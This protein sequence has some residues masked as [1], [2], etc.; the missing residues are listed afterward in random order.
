[1]LLMIENL[2]ILS[3]LLWKIVFNMIFILFGGFG[4]FFEI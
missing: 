4:F 2:S 1:M 3:S